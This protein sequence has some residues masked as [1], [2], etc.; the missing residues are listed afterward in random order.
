MRFRLSSSQQPYLN[1]RIQRR[2]LGYVALIALIMV[3]FQLLPG[4]RDPKAV[5]GPQDQKLDPSVFEVRPNADAPLAPDEFRSLPDSALPAG[6]APKATGGQRAA[7]PA[8]VLANVKDNTLGIRH[9]ESDAFFYTLDHLR[10]FS[11]EELAHAANPGVQYLNVMHDPSI[12]RGQPLTITGELWRMY[13]FP[14]S[15]NDFGLTKLYEAW[16]LTPD[17]GN[18]PFRVVCSSLGPNLSTKTALPIP[19]RVTGIFFKREG[20]DSQ[21]GLHVA[22]TLLASQ[23]DR[24]VSPNAPPEADSIVP[25]MLG[26]IVA[27]GLILATTLLSF[28]ISD[29]KTPRPTKRLPPIPTQTSDELSQIEF[30]SVRDQLI[31]LEER[32]LYSEWRSE[33]PAPPSTNGSHPTPRPA[34][35]IDLPTP[36]PPTQAARSS[37][38]E[39]RPRDLPETGPT[40]SDE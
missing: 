17:S 10:Q 23:L 29:R 32:E 27:V 19:V 13:E 6:S 37:R 12:Y 16:I 20:Y 35:T 26:F 3:I 9:D 8:S 30:R 5:K 24:Y 36:P 4:S 11:P 31:E 1:P 18:R 34:E 38:P 2:M 25:I 14:A 21:G 28:A 40:L 22:P 7:V 33:H 15:A 39:L